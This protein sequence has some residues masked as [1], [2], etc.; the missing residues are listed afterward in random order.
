MPVHCV[1]DCINL[2]LKVLLVLNK[3]N[4]IWVR[5]NVAPLLS[6]DNKYRWSYGSLLLLIVLTN[7]PR[8]PCQ[9]SLCFT[10][11]M[12]HLGWNSYG[13]GRGAGYPDGENVYTGE[14]SPCNWGFFARGNGDAIIRL[15][16]YMSNTHHDFTPDRERFS[17][18][19]VRN[20]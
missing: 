11:V 10:G 8:A 15:T 2:K 9:R 12:M 1:V 3:F 17:Y 13:G 6:N 20:S 4:S 5:C 16:K 19:S 7:V 18:V 14:L